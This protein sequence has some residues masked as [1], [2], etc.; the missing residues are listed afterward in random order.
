MNTVGIIIIMLPF[1]IGGVCL[2]IAILQLLEK[3]FPIHSAYI[4]NSKIGQQTMDKKPYFR[5]SGIVFAMIAGVF[6]AMGLDIIYDSG[7][8]VLV[9]L[10]LIVGG[11]AY[12]VISTK[13]MNK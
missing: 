12:A 4:F 1:I 3:G 9:Q 5:Q 10:L 8:F 6:I 2:L 11:I 13:K 7:I